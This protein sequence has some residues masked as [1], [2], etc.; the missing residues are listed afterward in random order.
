MRIVWLHVGMWLWLLLAV[1]PGCSES[2]SAG[3]NV[4]PRGRGSVSAGHE[5]RQVP[6]RRELSEALAEA[7]QAGKPLLVIF[8]TEECLYCHQ[9]LEKT[10][11]DA[12]VVA[13]AENFICVRIDA[14]QAPELCKDFDVEAFPTVQFITAEGVPLHRVL[15]K[16]EPEALIVQMQAALED[17]QS[18]TAYWGGMLR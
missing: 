7:R 17:P 14:S 10:F 8:S 6:F 15:G 12:Q 9:M 18:R 13:L 16:K 11:H 2:H 1:A 5:R 3:Q 4:G